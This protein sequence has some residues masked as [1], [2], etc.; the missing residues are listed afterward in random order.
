MAY[1]SCPTGF[2]SHIYSINGLGNGSDL[3]QF[4]QHTIGYVIFN[5]FG[6]NCRI[7]NEN[8]I[9]NNLNFI[10]QFGIH[11]FPSAPVIFCQAIFNRA[12]RIFGKH[13]FVIF[14]H[15]VA[16]N[17]LSFKQIL[18]IFKE[19]A[20]SS[21]NSQVNIF[22]GNITCCFNCLYNYD[23]CLFVGCQI[24]SKTTFITNGSY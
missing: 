1:N 18:S 3:I 16:V 2:M 12:N 7:G 17:F 11:F 15:S 21:I 19:T 8:I 13:T 22:T 23:K 10:A 4:N 9:A 14:N 5:A 20:G 6:N 24:G